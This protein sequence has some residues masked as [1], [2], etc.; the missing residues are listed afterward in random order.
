MTVIFIPSAAKSE[1]DLIEEA[2]KASSMDYVVAQTTEAIGI[3][4]KTSDA[5]IVTNSLNVTQEGWLLDLGEVPLFVYGHKE[6]SKSIQERI[7]K[8][9]PVPFKLGQII[10]DLKNYQ[11]HVVAQKKLQDIQLGDMLL[12]PSE[13]ILRNVQVDQEVYI[14][15]KELDILIYLIRSKKAV[16]KKELLQNIWQYADNVETHTLE[17][18][19]Y[20]LR[21]KIMTHIGC[22]NFLE[23]NDDGY[24]LSY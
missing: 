23:T 14:T 2:L 24:Y 4:D 16:G 17:T 15:D 1:Q 21:Q 12:I 22:D 10:Q 8:F 18:H 6:P 5:V 9:Y 13:R 3:V 11:Q 7:E 20:R 19:I